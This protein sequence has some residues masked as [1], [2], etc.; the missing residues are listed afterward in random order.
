MSFDIDEYMY[1]YFSLRYY[2]YLKQ[3]VTI[4][5]YTVVCNTHKVTFYRCHL[6]KKYQVVKASLGGS[7][8]HGNVRTQWHKSNVLA[9]PL[10]A[11]EKSANKFNY[12]L[13][14][15]FQISLP[16]NSVLTT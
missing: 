10:P 14:V 7:L 13:A 12:R 4:L 5:G 2:Q 11:S 3:I 8:S 16:L 9:Y 1:I 6:A 15:I